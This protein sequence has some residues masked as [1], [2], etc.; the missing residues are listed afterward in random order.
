MAKSR[1]KRPTSKVRETVPR[2]GRPARPAG[3]ERKQLIVDVALLEAAMEVT[4][5]NQSET[6]NEALA[7]LTENAAILRGFEEAFGA[8]P[9]H[10]DHHVAP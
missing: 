8:S 9:E 6:V 10:P 4:G 2:P 1:T 3:R 5:G 7:H